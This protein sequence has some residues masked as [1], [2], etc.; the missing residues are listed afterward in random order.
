MIT[1][2]YSYK[3]GVGRT[4][5]ALEVAVQLAQAGHRVTFWD[6]DLEA[7]GVQRNPSL[8]ALDQSVKTGTIDA[9]EEFQRTGRYPTELVTASLL[10]LPVGGG[11]R[12]QFL[13]PGVLDPGRVRGERLVPF[14]TRYAAI[15]W[16]QLFDPT[17]GMGL[18]L[19]LCM[20]AQLEEEGAVDHLIIDGRTGVNELA[21]LC[22]AELPDVVVLVRTAGAQSRM[23]TQLVRDALARRQLSGELGRPDLKVWTVANLVP[24]S[25][26]MAVANAELRHLVE[27]TAAEVRGEVVL[28]I[29]FALRQQ[30]DERPPSLAG[31][32]ARAETEAVA[33][34]VRRL[35][36]ELDARRRLAAG[37]RDER[38]LRR[39]D[40][41]E[42]RLRGHEG[43]DRGARFEDEVAA[44]FRMR[45]AEVTTNRLE[46]D[47][48]IDVWATYRAGTSIV[49]EIVECK[50]IG[51]VGPDVVRVLAGKVD[52]IHRTDHRG[53][54]RGIIVS[55]SGF[56]KTAPKAAEDNGIALCTL[57][58]LTRQLVDLE[59]E[60]R[61]IRE[62]WS[63]SGTEALYIEPDVVVHGRARPGERVDAAPLRNELHR[64]LADD[65]T[66]VF[67]LLG[68]FGT[69]KT[70]F[71]T[72]LAAEMAAAAAD[73]PTARVPVLVD[74]RQTRTTH[75][76]LDG[77]LRAHLDRRSIGVSP[78]ALRQR[79]RAGH[80][81]LI[82]D[83]FDEMLGYAE[84]GQ[85]AQNLRQVLGAAEG[86]G[87]VMLTCRTNFF[88]NRPEEL[89]LIG[90]VPA[91]VS[92]PETTALWNLVSDHPGVEIG[93]LAPFTAEQRES[94]VRR[95]AG[96]GADDLLDAMR[97]THDLVD[98]G[99]VP[100][101]L[102]LIVRASPE[103]VGLDGQ[104]VTLARLYEVF[105]EHWFKRGKDQLRLL[106]PHPEEV[107]EELARRL[108]ESPDRGMHYDAIAE[109]AASLT[110]EQP[111]YGPLERDQIDYEI[112]SALFLTR[113]A[114][115]YFRFA[116]RSFHEYF[117]ARRLRA[118]LLA[119]DT[120]CLDLRPLTKEVVEFL[121][122]M[123]G[124]AA[125]VRQ[126]VGVLHDRPRRRVTENALIVAH[127]ASR[128][129]G[130][131]ADLR[132]ARLAGTELGGLDLD[133]ADLRNADMTDANL[134]WATMED[135]DLRN[136]DLTSAQ[137]S[138]VLLGR[139]DLTG[140]SLRSASAD[141]VL[142][143]GSILS[144][145]DITGADLS[146]GRLVS[147]DLRGVIGLE[148]ADL[149]GTS[150]A[151]CSPGGSPDG[152]G[153]YDDPA[154]AGTLASPAN[155]FP[156]HSMGFHPCRAGVL[157]TATNGTVRVV[158]LAAG[159]VV[160]E[161]FH[162]GAGAVAW[163]P[164]GTRL[165]SGGDDGTVRTWDPATGAEVARFEGHGD[166]VQA[167][168]WS[169]DGTRLAS[170]G[171][172]G[173]VR[174]W[175]PAT[176]AEVARFEG[177]RSGVR[178]VAWSPDGTRLA[179]GGDDG[180]IALSRVGS[181]ATAVRLWASGPD[182]AV[183][184]AAGWAKV[185][186]SLRTQISVRIG[187]VNHPIAEVPER[188][189]DQAVD[190]VLRA[191]AAP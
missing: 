62:A 157:A 161:L 97:R 13:L 9:V 173:T 126:C 80:L 147:T 2:F 59:P 176:G 46:V 72:S 146:F 139:A 27:T 24:N 86:R 14:D 155:G 4:A 41:E 35:A 94:Y 156:V 29:P 112:R 109:L 141:H 103:L 167:V 66:P 8:T 57:D 185:P 168:A 140:A 133:R 20:A 191:L 19:F 162:S 60:Q 10:D 45:G 174:T 34:L 172:D 90:Q 175:D 153:R 125:V 38:R 108:W 138:F 184:T 73:D 154:A 169:P 36:E 67:A 119:G 32:S 149:Y 105:A 127:R 33:P 65:T 148:S 98:L 180:T 170:G 144:H 132:G 134:R 91:A 18:P 186:E 42:R 40:S 50:D 96:K 55:R 30:V 16:A 74:L 151:R 99:R 130:L 89:D 84:P 69:G 177:H 124:A 135:A 181:D 131:T 143:H 145:A 101:L 122:G 82:F 81:L 102:S 48:E 43:R 106:G 142:G 75:A 39:L 104:R 179:T 85:F 25:D 189:D 117:L 159:E 6:L 37:E 166:W 158:D 118:R 87:K 51:A 63:G 114:G 68:D 52:Q 3:G 182:A 78:A 107:V 71:C 137:L 165:A 12:L 150:L 5:L 44:L 56:T 54:Y 70:T 58:D 53:F 115:G 129:H 136:A 188:L 49:N 111:A 47:M 164:D 79:S 121:C 95:A 178:A 88:R 110:R 100:Y 187:L 61:A 23:G 26:G 77:L 113:D 116:H 171:D 83:G 21:A 93:Y 123:D 160:A 183:L 190:E 7:P 22:A 163:S 15:D 120:A 17:K 152:T 128:D 11:G 92:D 64:W 1:S 31:E 28:A 76:T